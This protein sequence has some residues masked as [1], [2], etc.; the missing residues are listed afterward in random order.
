MREPLVPPDPPLRDGD[1][2]LRTWRIDDADAVLRACQDPE[3]PRWIPLPQPYLRHHA[4]DFV[5][6]RFGDWADGAAPFAIVDAATDRLLGAITLHPREGSHAS[7]GYWLAPEARGRGVMTRAVRL[8]SRWAFEVLPIARLQLYTL[9]GNEQSGAVAR[10]AGFTREG[11]LRRWDDEDG[12]ARD[13]VMFS[14]IREDL[15]TR[16]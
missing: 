11:I 12:I 4:E 5:T 16:D 2:Q 13:V 10:R 7:V 8:V 6:G 3:I 14:L 1:I 9:V 15:A